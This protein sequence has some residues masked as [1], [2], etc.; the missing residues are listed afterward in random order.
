MDLVRMHRR[1]LMIAALP[2]ALFGGMAVPAGHAAGVNPLPAVATALNGITS[3]QVVVTSSSNGAFRRPTSG[4]RP[5][6]TPRLGSG[7]GLGLGFGFG[8]QSR[9]ITAVRKNGLFEDHL[10]ITGKDRAGKTTITNV[11]IYGS[12]VCR[13]N[14]GAHSYTC[15]KTSQFNYT[16]DP[17]A[18]FT[19]GAGSTT[20]TGTAS[21]TIGGHACNGYAYTNQSQFGTT[22]GTVYIAATTNLPCEQVQTT[23]RHIPNS[24]STFT[25]T[26][27]SVWSHF[28][29]KSLSVPAIP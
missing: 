24:S 18:A 6:A 8:N 22:K 13:E 5:P 16:L 23:T 25:Q 9:T 4:S 20:F 12:T 15:Q 11:L 27:T 7:R 17:T 26:T 2:L 21:K 19:Q 29:D 3:Y 10:V 1:L 14:S 28:N